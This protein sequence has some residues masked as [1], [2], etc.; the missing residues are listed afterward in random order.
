MEDI[1][2]QTGELSSLGLWAGTVRRNGREA[3]RRTGRR[4]SVKLGQG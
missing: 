4:G 2:T 3:V 1:G